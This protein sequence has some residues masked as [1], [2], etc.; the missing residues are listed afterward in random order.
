MKILID[1]RILGAKHGGIGRYTLNLVQ[2][3]VKLDSQNNYVLLVNVNDIDEISDLPKNWEIIKVNFKHYSVREQF[4]L[5]SLLNKIKPDLVHF[6]HFN[7]PI[8]YK[9]N[10]VVTIHDLSMHKKSGLNSTT[11]DP[12][13]FLIKRI[14]YKIVFKRAIKNSTKIIVPSNFVKEEL[15]TFFKISKDKILV[16]YEGIE[17]KFFAI[18]KKL[19]NKYGKYFLYA[20]SVYPHKNLDRAIEAFDYFKNENYHFLITGLNNKFKDRLQNKITNKKIKVLGFVNDDELINLMKN[21]EAFIFPSI[22]EGFGLPGLEAMASKTIL[23]CSDIFVFKEIYK[24]NAIYFNPFDF[25]EI[26][27]AFDE[28]VLLD[29][30]K[31]KNKIEKAYKYAQKFSL[32][33]CAKET[34]N[35][36]ESCNSL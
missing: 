2:T 19:D 33:N 25:S 22:M 27:K 1:A 10:Y 6:T 4:Q 34:L 3:L 20:G 13:T 28:V 23:V 14:A 16:V 29:T 26:T 35:I 12:L 5:L 21:A 30:N 32:L 15:N 11:K 24:D 17:E 8:F 7:I 18:K 31:R 9:K 36:Y